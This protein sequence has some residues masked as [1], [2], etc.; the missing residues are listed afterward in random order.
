MRKLIKSRLTFRS[1]LLT[2]SVN[3]W[4]EPY[5]KGGMCLRLISDD[6][7]QE[8]IATLTRCTPPIVPDF[9][10][11][12]IKDDDENEGVGDWL[13]REGL[14]YPTGKGAPSGFLY[15][16]EFRMLIS[17]VDGSP[18]PGA[19][20]T[21]NEW[22]LINR[23]TKEPMTKGL[24]LPTRTDTKVMLLGGTPPHKEGST[25]RVHVVH[26]G[27]DACTPAEYFPSVVEAHWVKG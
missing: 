15:F 10:C 17:M 7:I 27:P 14:A 1:P 26:L 19:P 2:C 12:H 24:I 3:L 22:T 16:P 8:P 20:C 9:Q 18:V 5:V 6:D 4:A 23:N 21:H 25:G 11:V 13:M